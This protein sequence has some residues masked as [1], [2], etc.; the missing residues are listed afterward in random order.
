MCGSGSL[1]YIHNHQLQL[2]AIMIIIMLLYAYFTVQPGFYSTNWLFIGK[3]YLQLGKVSEGGEWLKKAA[4]HS[5]IMEE[6]LAA[7]R[8][9]EELLKKLGIDPN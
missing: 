3:C 8:E 5:S 2:L 1:N 9:A 4:S 6:D 7:K